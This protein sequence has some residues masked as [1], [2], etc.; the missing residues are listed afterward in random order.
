MVVASRSSG[1]DVEVGDRPAW[2]DA[3]LIIVVAAMVLDGGD[4]QQRHR[5]LRDF[6]APQHD[7]KSGIIK[8]IAAA[9]G[10][11]PVYLAAGAGLEV[12]EMLAGSG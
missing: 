3:V 11:C 7:A 4:V 5:A 10:N 8:D 1:K 12:A 2:L 6:V 9:V